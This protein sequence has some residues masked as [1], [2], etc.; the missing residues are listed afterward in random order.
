MRRDG[1]LEPG[2]VVDILGEGHCII[3]YVNTTGARAIPLTP[4]YRTVQAHDSKTGASKT[5]QFKQSRDGF[6]IS[7]HSAVKLVG[8]VEGYT[9]RAD[10]R[11][12]TMGN[13]EGALKA[14]ATRAKN[15]AAAKASAEEATDRLVGKIKAAPAGPGGVTAGIE[16][17][18]V[19]AAEAAANGASP[20][21]AAAAG[22]DAMAIAAS[23]DPDLIS[24]APEP[25]V[26]LGNNGS[27]EDTNVA[28]N[29]KANGKVKAN[30]KAGTARTRTPKAP[31]ELKP[32]AC[33]CGEQT[34]GYFV[35]GHDARFKGRML[36]IE[37]GEAKKSELLPAAVIRK[38]EWVGT[39]GGGERTTTNYKGEK[40]S[41]YDKAGRE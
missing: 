31:K 25:G 11:R 15:R 10:R 7:S 2:D 32:C 35:Q 5:V 29:G 19:A 17:G 38:Y 9:S 13:R 21:E 37:R 16:T 28:R 27:Q 8:R 26:D 23:S 36:K 20:A 24:V 22:A 39:K 12:D 40:H 3:D 41:G 33:G 18:I 34:G 1:Q 30:R 4:V 6:T 14:A